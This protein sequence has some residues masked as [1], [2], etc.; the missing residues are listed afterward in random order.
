MESRKKIYPIDIP[1]TFR[2]KNYPPALS[3]RSDTFPIPKA[4]KFSLVGHNK[5]PD[6]YK[7]NCALFQA[8]T[9]ET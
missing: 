8:R 3:R 4:T 5:F 2:A 1:K 9:H 7:L 6:I